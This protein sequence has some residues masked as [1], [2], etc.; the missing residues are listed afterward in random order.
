MIERD[1]S[2]RDIASHLVNLRREKM[3]ALKRQLAEVGATLGTAEADPSKLTGI[4]RLRLLH[5]KVGTN[6]RDGVERRPRNITTVD[7][8]SGNKELKQRTEAIPTARPQLDDEAGLATTTRRTTTRPRPTATTTP[9]TT[10]ATTTIKPMS[11]HGQQ[12][13]SKVLVTADGGVW[14]MSKA[15]TIVVFVLGS[16]FLLLVAFVVYKYLSWKPKMVARKGY[17]AVTKSKGLAVTESGTDGGGEA[18][19][20]ARSPRLNPLLVV[21]KP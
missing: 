7:S 4:R 3:Q 18:S 13:P 15:V 21:T 20:G 6:G 16:S 12:G 5:S 11:Q 9:S 8:T 2:N 17:R 19:E 1:T 10:T 14:G